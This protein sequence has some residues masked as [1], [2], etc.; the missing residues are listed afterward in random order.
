MIAGGTGIAPMLQLIRSIVKVPTDKTKISLLF[1]NQSEDDIL[2]R[3]ELEEV[4]KNHPDRFKFWYTVDKSNAGWK[5]STG[6]IDADM[7]SQHMY[8]PSPDTI[9]LVCG[10]PPMISNA[11]TPNLDKL[12]YDTTRRFIY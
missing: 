11:C 12:G 2:L 4:A 1:A 8:P 7:I 9:V 3:H 10:P 6:Y 5:Y